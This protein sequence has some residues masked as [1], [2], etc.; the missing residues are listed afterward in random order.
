MQVS[1]LFLLFG[2]WLNTCAFC[3]IVQVSQLL[4]L[5]MQTLGYI[6]FCCNKFWSYWLFS[7]HSAVQQMAIFPC[8]LRR[9]LPTAYYSLLFTVIKFQLWLWGKINELTLLDWL[10]QCYLGCGFH[11]RLAT[12]SRDMAMNLGNIPIPFPMTFYKDYSTSKLLITLFLHKVNNLW[13]F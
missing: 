13:T 12:I 2:F 6:V 11:F 10:R 8:R 4:C 9:Y 3:I 7:M 1:D 5:W